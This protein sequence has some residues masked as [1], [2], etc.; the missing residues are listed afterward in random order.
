[1]KTKNVDMNSDISAMYTVPH[2]K[3]L[4]LGSCLATLH[5]LQYII[6]SRVLS[7]K[8]LNQFSADSICCNL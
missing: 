5:V 6:I 8:I 2:E 4:P 3:T 7:I 1:M